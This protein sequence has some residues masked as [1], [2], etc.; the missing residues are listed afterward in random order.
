M[1]RLAERH[2]MP[3]IS[4]SV[5]ITTP[6]DPS[7]LSRLIAQHFFPPTL[8]SSLQLFQLPCSD[9][10]NP[11]K[12]Y[13]ISSATPVQRLSDP[14]CVTL[15]LGFVVCSSVGPNSPHPASV[16]TYHT[17]TSPT[18][19]RQ[20]PYHDPLRLSIQKLTSQ[21]LPRNTHEVLQ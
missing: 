18:R 20:Y 17:S 4:V 9:A 13:Y 1:P 21:R 14:Q 2:V 19:H 15:S 16:Y 12:T 8:C 3:S 10:L 11:L 5:S 7:I 6:T